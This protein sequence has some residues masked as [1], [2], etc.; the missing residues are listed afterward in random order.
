MTVQIAWSEKTPGEVHVTFA[1]HITA[2]GLPVIEAG[3]NT[4]KKITCFL[5]GGMLTFDVEPARK[6]AVE[7]VRAH[8][9]TQK[10]SN[11]GIYEFAH[12]V[13]ERVA[14]VAWHVKREHGSWN[15]NHVISE[16]MAHGGYMT[17]NSPAARLIGSTA[18]AVLEVLKED[19]PVKN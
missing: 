7:F 12:G 19:K 2:C 11:E 18:Q 13:A 6:K 10:W 15:T 8:P 5:C 14:G 4:P 17:D 3:G 9:G 16:F 1:G